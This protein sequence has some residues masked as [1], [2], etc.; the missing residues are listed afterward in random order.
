MADKAQVSILPNG[1]RLEVFNVKDI[2][3]DGKEDAIW[4]RCGSAFVNKDGSLNVVLD[5]LPVNGKLNIR[6]PNPKKDQGE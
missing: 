6:V 3:R 5:L 2:E 4:N 1:T